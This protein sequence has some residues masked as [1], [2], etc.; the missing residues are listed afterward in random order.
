MTSG[1]RQP[2]SEP[3]RHAFLVRR[4]VSP[5]SE[6]IPRHWYGGDPFATHFLNALSSNFPFGEAF[7]V[8]S[9]RRYLDR[10]EDPGRREEI[11]RFAGQEA[12]H[13]RVHD[14]HMA[15]LVQQGYGA[16]A[17]RNRFFDRI[18]RW[19]N[20]NTPRLSLAM[21]ASLEHMTTILARR[22]LSGED[23]W[24]R[25]MHPEMARLWRWHALEEAEH[26][27]VA[28]D[29]LMTVAPAHWLRVLA[30]V[31]NSFDLASE[32]LQRMI[33]MLWK[34]GL[35]FDASV[36]NGGRRFLFGSQ[37]FLRGTGPDYLAW[38][39]ADFHPEDI[40]DRAMIEETAPRVTR[41]LAS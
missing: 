11:R 35:L 5:L 7:F 31:L 33:Y 24:T 28:F 16:L 3:V 14:E 37:G 6:A 29:V 34:D 32:V 10:I 26:K 25:A 18:L 19:H 21:T 12:Q 4:P 39:R 38:Y 15:L 36:W 1:S 9:V 41:E 22:L 17:T 20:R 27:S 30:M 13:S 23:R 2:E 8:R 40:D